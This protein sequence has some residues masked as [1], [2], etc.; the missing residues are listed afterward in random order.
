MP[1]EKILVV[2]DEKGMRVFFEIMLKKEGFRVSTCSSGEEAVEYLKKN[3]CGLVITDIKMPGM[4]GIG[5]LKAVK[6]ISPETIVIM[7]TAYASVETAIE[8]MKL[9]A[10]DYFT[11]PFKVD[12][13]KLHIIKALDLK[14]L[15]KENLLLRR[16]LKGK[17]GF[18][19]L[20]GTS[21]S[22]L[23]VY[24]LIRRVVDTKTNIFITGESGTGKEL[25]ARAIHYEGGRKDKPFVAIN[26]GAIPENLLESELFGHQKGAFTGAIANKA[27]LFEVADGGTVFL[28]EITEMPLHLQVKLLRFIQD[29]SFRRVGSTEDITIDVRIISASNRDVENDVRDG[30]FREDLFY[31]LNVIHIPMPPLRDR[32]EDIP[33]LAEHFLK[34]CSKK[35][36]KDIRGISSEAMGY[37][38]SYRFPGNARELE[39]IIE[40]AIALE[41]SNI[42]LPERLPPNV[43]EGYKG[44]EEAEINLVGP[45]KIPPDG[46]N[47]EMTIEGF[48]KRILIDALR[49]AGGVKKKAAGLLRLSFRSMRYKLDKYGLG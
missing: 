20:I 25:V 34:K 47:L 26:C 29:N 18:S 21:P 3:S 13:I 28:D 23:A 48:E 10:Y 27:G 49:E 1:K 43:L 14:R 5:L 8:A 38:K 7:I 36:G 30:N 35:L 24:D 19:N 39:N 32:M 46:L 41:S 12:D 45:T 11:K 44:G 22:M 15:E 9:G 31:R 33:L 17:Y 42:V 2:D 16:E 4:G 6:E 40:R 37:L